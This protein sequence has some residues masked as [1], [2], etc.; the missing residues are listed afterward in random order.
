MDRVE[1]MSIVLHAVEAGS[2]SKASRNLGLPLATVSRKISELEAHLNTTLFTRSAKGLMPTPAGHSFITAARA[3]LELVNEA[4]RTASGE[5]TAPKGDLA[6]SAPTMF[7][8]LHVLPVLKDFLNAYPEVDIGLVLT[9]RIAHFVDDQVDVALRIGH[10]PDSALTAIRLGSVRRVVC[11]SPAYFAQHG[12]PVTPDDLQYRPAITF[13][14]VSAPGVWHFYS[15][16]IQFDT[17]LRSRLSVN[18]TDAAIDAAIAGM[19]LARAN[20]YQIVDHVRRGALVLTLEAFEPPS[21]PVSLIYNSHAR[22]PLKLRAFI[23]FVTPR[24]RA[25]L[26]DATL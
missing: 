17:A 3:I 25:R 18:T 20:S 2:L 1:A 22:L 8:R 12:A 6:V 23:D 21:R 14:N 13:E 9:D 4:E 15:G 10:L 19:G 11:A 16:G 7:G 26:K 5:Y 24:L